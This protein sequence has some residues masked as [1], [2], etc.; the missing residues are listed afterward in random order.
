M[1]RAV[2]RAL[3]PVLA[4]AVIVGCSSKP[5]VP[6]AFSPGAVH[7]VPTATQGVTLRTLISNRV[8][9]IAAD[10]ANVWIATDKGVSRLVRDTG[11]WVHYTQE[12]G[13]E[14][15]D[16]RDVVADENTVWFG[17]SARLC[18]YDV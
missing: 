10:A 9:A 13:L 4:A 17:T 3:L 2:I 12:D 7:G 11:A 5:G 6:T 18:V 15:D 1:R 16:I 8:R 14:S